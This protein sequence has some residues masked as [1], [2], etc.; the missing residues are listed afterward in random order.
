MGSLGGC[1]LARAVWAA[2]WAR[3]PAGRNRICM[4]PFRAAPPPKD[5][6]HGRAEAVL[7]PLGGFHLRDGRPLL[8]QHR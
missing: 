5:W 2:G 4:S 8:Y 6:E 3:I 7:L 1:G